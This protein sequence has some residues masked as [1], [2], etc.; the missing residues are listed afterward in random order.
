MF[1]SIVRRDVATVVVK[2]KHQ[3]YCKVWS[4]QPAHTLLYTQHAMQSQLASSL[5]EPPCAM[6]RN[7]GHVHQ[8]SRCHYMHIKDIHYT[9]RHNLSLSHCHFRSYAVVQ[10]TN[11]SL[12]PLP[13]G[14]PLIATTTTPSPYPFTLTTP[15]TPPLYTNICSSSL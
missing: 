11:W 14:P 3:F 6:T 15:L 7:E 5:I 2:N 12:L 8:T 13:T 9:N 4:G 1:V 10:S